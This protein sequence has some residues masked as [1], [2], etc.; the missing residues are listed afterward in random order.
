MTRYARGP[1]AVLLVLA[2]AGCS[3]NRSGINTGGKLTGQVTLNGKP[4][5]G[6][7]VLVVSEDGKFSASGYVN[8]EG[9]YTVPEPPLG[10]V[11]IAL[12]TSHLRGSMVPKGTGP[13]SG[14]SNEGSRG[15]VMPNPKEIGLEF[16][17]I[18]AKY[19]NPSTSD[20]RFEVKGGDETHDLQLTAQ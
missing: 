20:L 17:E 10:K 8:G 14:G 19:E 5:K 6:G 7:N 9:T 4:I 13:K 12:Q 1:V 2:L 18:P 3:G 16:T 15:M 11:R